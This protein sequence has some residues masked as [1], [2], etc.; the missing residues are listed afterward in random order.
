MEECA[1]NI[2]KFA[3]DKVWH[4]ASQ[5]ATRCYGRGNSSLHTRDAAWRWVVRDGRQQNRKASG[6]A[7]GDGMPA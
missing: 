3:G 4:G 7:Y 1:T 5:S 6:L 2:L